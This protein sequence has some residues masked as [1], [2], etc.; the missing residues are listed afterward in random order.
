MKK[1]MQIN[2][3]CGRGS[4]G[5]ISESLYYATQKQGNNSIFAYS[6]YIPTVKNVFK[7]ENR[8]QNVL[9]RALNK[10]VGRRQ[11]HSTPGTKRLIRYIKREKP[12]LIHLH[13][14]QQNSVN[15]ELLF[16]F[17]KASNIPIVYTLHDCWSFTG[18]CYH[19][20]QVGC[21]QYQ[22]GC[23]NCPQ[24]SVLDDAL[25]K[26]NDAYK[27]KADLIGKNENIHPV[28]VSKWLCYVAKE[29]YMGKMKN[30]PQVI[31]NGIDT[32]VFYPRDVDRFSKLGIEKDEFV[33]LGVASF[34]TEEKGMSLFLKIAK[35][36]DFKC[37]VILIGGGLEQIKSESDEKIICVERTESV[38]ELADYYS[39]ADVFI[40]TSIE[41][42]FGLTTAE[43]LACGTPAI[44]FNSTACPEI[45]D[46]KTGICVDYNQVEIDNVVE[47][48]H[49]IRENGKKHYT[50]ECI[51][52]VNAL[53]TKERMIEKYL[54]L[55]EEILS[56]KSS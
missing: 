45:V 2:I 1:I 52:R 11:K 24:K 7:I 19:F 49:R 22:T 3:T 56:E 36:L 34:W 12:A 40:N 37:R 16:K 39:L 33:V 48:I 47:A 25:R 14:V 54:A 44:V 18:G 38:L 50:K 5:R 26:A 13:N 31:Y 4:T 6:A 41:E 55:Y 46:E 23:G 17:L 42:T 51:N 20:T 10:Y 21:D 27:I 8:L 53:F 35:R 15:Y 32:T 29:S 9:R 30:V 28:C 43:A